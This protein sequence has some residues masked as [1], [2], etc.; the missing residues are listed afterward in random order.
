M[1]ETHIGFG[2]TFDYIK[3]ESKGYNPGDKVIVKDNTRFIIAIIQSKKGPKIKLRNIDGSFNTKQA[4]RCTIHNLIKFGFDYSR[5]EEIIA[6]QRIIPIILSPK[7]T[8]R[9]THE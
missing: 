2:N 9:K 7:E 8:R 1:Y 4:I 6:G 5:A 3:L